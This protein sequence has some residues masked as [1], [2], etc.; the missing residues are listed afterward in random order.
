VWLRATMME[1]GGTT[2]A[3]NDMSQLPVFARHCNCIAVA[4]FIVRL[5]DQSNATVTTKSGR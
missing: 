4:V 1:G 3:L 2:A 5:T